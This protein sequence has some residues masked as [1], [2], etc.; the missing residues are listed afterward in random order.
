MTLHC[1]IKALIHQMQIKRDKLEILKT[2]CVGRIFQCIVLCHTLKA[3]FAE[4]NYESTAV[5]I[6]KTNNNNLLISWLS[7]TKMT[8][9]SYTVLR[10]FK[11]NWLD[12]WHLFH[13]KLRTVDCWVSFRTDSARI[14]MPTGSP[15][16]IDNVVDWFHWPGLNQNW[17][18]NEL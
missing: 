14:Q 13:H 18:T 8:Y 11:H 15:K 3:S 4:F 9:I 5:Y 16:L 2:L 17:G 7:C 10:T 6:S 1:A 12:P